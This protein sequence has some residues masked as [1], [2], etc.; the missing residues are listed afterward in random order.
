MYI[1]FTINIGVFNLTRQLSNF[2]QRLRNAM[3][4]TKFRVSLANFTPFCN[5]S[6]RIGIIPTV[7]TKSGKNFGNLLGKNYSRKLKNESSYQIAVSLSKKCL[8]IWSM[9]VN[10]AHHYK[11]WNWTLALGFLPVHVEPQSFCFILGKI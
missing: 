5:S 7:L 6:P 1:N 11:K 3:L 8:K 2:F 4:Q 10:L 9:T